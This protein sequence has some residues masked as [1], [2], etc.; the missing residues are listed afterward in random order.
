MKNMFV[1]A[2]D[3]VAADFVC[4]QL[5]GLDPSLVW[6]F[7]RDLQ[8]LSHGSPGRIDLIAERLPLLVAPFDILPEFPHLQLGS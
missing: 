3:P 2:D 1:L 4:A 6:Q 5:M 8:F 7:D